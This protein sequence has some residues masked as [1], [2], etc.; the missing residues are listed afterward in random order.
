M[1]VLVMTRFF[2]KYIIHKS[3]KRISFLLRL[4]CDA[5]DL[6]PDLLPLSFLLLVKHSALHVLFD[7]TCGTYSIIFLQTRHFL[8]FAALFWAANSTNFFVFPS[9][10]RTFNIGQSK[11]LRP[12]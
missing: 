12:I 6:R 9:L 10:L 4:F 2:P 1:G 8:G 7:L 11:C 3:A 5:A